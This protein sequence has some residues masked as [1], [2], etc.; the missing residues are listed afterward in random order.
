MELVR[1][2]WK[3]G[4]VAFRVESG[5]DLWVLENVIAPGDT[6]SGVTERKLKLGSGRDEK[7][8]VVRKK[9]RL[10]IRVEKV[11]YDGATLRV[12]GTIIE[13]PEEVPRGEH[14]SF[15]LAPGVTAA[16]RKSSWPSYLRQKL[17]D[18]TRNV[19]SILVL[20]FDREE[21]RLFGVTR[22]G[23]EELARRKGLVPKKRLSQGET[24]NFYRE[25]V[26]LLTEYVGRGYERVVAGAPAFWKEYLQK[27][28][29]PE[30]KKKTVL[31][32]ISGVERTAIRELLARPEVAKLLA[33]SR[34]L[35]EL[36]LVEKVKVALS[37]D[38]LAYGMEAVRAAVSAGNVSLVVVTEHFFAAEREAGRLAHLEELLREA[39]RV[40]GTV[41]VLSSDEAAG[42][43][44]AL[45]GIVAVKRW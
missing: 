24:R 36:S 40:D 19:P 14:H 22:R 21:A 43:I 41:Q 18:A 1:Q 5:D 13:G 8:S 20:L 45:T 26:A 10:A 16:L 4:V 15:V 27:E 33:E 30:L 35:R 2:Q 37:H 9:V 28:L 3:E 6:L 31:T 32:T 7:Q 12:L 34:A 29:P 39:E 17:V 44:D 11:E 42:E 38:R 23:V 25:L